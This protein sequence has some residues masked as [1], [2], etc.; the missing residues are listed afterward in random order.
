[1]T[2]TTV[3]T[4]ELLDRVVGER[5]PVPGHPNMVVVVDDAHFVA[6]AVWEHA[7]HARRERWIDIALR[8][9]GA[10]PAVF[11]RKG[12]PSEVF[13]VLVVIADPEL[14]ADR[15]MLLRPRIR[16]LRTTSVGFGG[17]RTV[18]WAV[19]LRAPIEWTL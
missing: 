18:G 19:D 5:G 15:R 16:S 1:M 6:Q 17:N 11:D 12:P 14:G 7:N 10:S 3:E 13:D 8:G 2:S 4:E 9:Q